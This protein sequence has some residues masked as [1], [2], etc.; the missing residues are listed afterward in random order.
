LLSEY[1]AIPSKNVVDE[2]TKH[3]ARNDSTAPPSLGAKG[4]PEPDRG[5][6]EFFNIPLSSDPQKFFLEK[7]SPFDEHSWVAS[8][9][10]QTGYKIQFKDYFFEPDLPRSL[11]VVDNQLDKVLEDLSVALS[12]VENQRQNF[13]KGLVSMSKSGKPLDG[14]EWLGL[15]PSHWEIVPLWAVFKKTKRLNFEGEE[16]LALYRD[17]GVIPKASRDDN[18]NV[19]SQDLSRY[20]LVEPGDLVVNK[21]KAWQGSV[22]IST[23]RGIISPAYFVY[24]PLREINSRFMHHLLRSPGYFNQY[25]KLSSGVRPGQW[26]LDPIAFKTLSIPLPSLEEQTEIATRLDAE[27]EALDAV[28]SMADSLIDLLSERRKSQIGAAITGH[29]GLV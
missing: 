10:T 13:T 16:L 15:I 7:I 9:K 5:L 17:Y 26:D 21:M 14:L 25:S 27:L 1:I 2:V 22:A 8:E 20:Q 12:E 11:K 24:E 19:E 4:T 29:Q 3:C 28:V 23:I 18:H 6:R